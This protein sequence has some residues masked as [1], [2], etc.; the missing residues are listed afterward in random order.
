MN[1]EIDITELKQLPENSYI[2]IDIRD[3]YAFSCGHVDGAVNIP[4]KKLD[5]EYTQLPKDKSL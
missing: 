4:Q 1:S 2:L 3:E 5:E